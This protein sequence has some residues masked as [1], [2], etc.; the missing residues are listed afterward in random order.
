M[1]FYLN[2][3]AKNNLFLI[4]IIANMFF[5]LSENIIFAVIKESTERKSLLDNN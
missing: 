5:Y 4:Y 3:Y 1:V 2:E